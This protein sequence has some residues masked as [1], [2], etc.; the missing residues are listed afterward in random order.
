MNMKYLIENDQMYIEGSKAWFVDRNTNE[1]ITMDMKTMK[2]TYKGQVPITD[3]NAFR[4][5]PFLCVY[6][7]KVFLLPDYGKEVWL[8]DAE[9]EKL[10]E[11]EVINKDKVAI[12]TS[13]KWVYNKRLYFVSQGL[14]KLVVI[15]IQTKKVEKY[16]DVFDTIGTFSF[17]FERIENTVYLAS[18]T[19]NIILELDLETESLKYYS[20]P[21]MKGGIGTI[22]FDGKVFWLSGCEK[23][24][25]AWNKEDNTV[26]VFEDFPEDFYVYD[27]TNVPVKIYSGKDVM[28]FPIFLKSVLLK[29]RILFIPWNITQV[30]SE[31]MICMNLQ[32]NMMTSIKI[33]DNEKCAA[34]CTYEY[35]RDDVFIG[36]LSSEDDYITEINIETLET[37]QQQMYV[38][39]ECLEH[40]NENQLILKGYYNEFCEGDIGYLIKQASRNCEDE[41]YSGS[42]IGC[43]IFQQTGR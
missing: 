22:C 34:M 9:E 29:N 11:I 8:F 40:K 39:E 42:D 15:D 33:A 27:R 4:C 38:D 5:N 23:R 12:K 7:Q 13:A 28:P 21:E 30:C 2:C 3:G 1:L 26:I 31:K 41:R 24:L 25:Y 14:R 16:V 6:E 32:D 19:S 10:Y 37:K 18:R 17:A 43:N 36:V 35:I 20:I